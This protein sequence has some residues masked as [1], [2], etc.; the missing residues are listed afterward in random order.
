M[1]PRPDVSEERKSQIL[2]AAQIIFAKQGFHKARIDDIAK[3]A[4]LSKGAVYWYFKSKDEII[5]ALLHR[6]FEWEVLYLQ[7]LVEEE[8]T[9]QERLQ[10]YTDALVQG[11]T[12]MREFLPIMYEFYALSSRRKEI[13]EFLQSYFAQFRDVVATIVQQG[14]ERKEIKPVNETDMALLLTALTEGMTILWLIHPDMIDL[15]RMGRFSIQTILEPLI[16]T[17]P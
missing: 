12:S 7:N 13:Q 3:Q 6:I 17:K 15:D 5:L 16:V 2:E 8:G 10:G 1:S 4:G 9:I 11:M 14:V